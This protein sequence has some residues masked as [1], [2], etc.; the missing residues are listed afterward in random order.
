MRKTLKIATAALLA[1]VVGT[2][3]ALAHEMKGSTA[4]PGMGQGMMGSQMK[5][6]S[7]MGAGMMMGGGY[8]PC[9]NQAGGKDLSADDARTILDGHL[10]MMGHKRLKVG[11][12]TPD[13][14]GALIADI[15]TLDGSLVLKMEV[16]PGTGAMH[17]V[18]E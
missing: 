18:A 13:K 16:D 4:A 5:M 15:T 14:D 3:V 2:G 9:Q 8:G 7:G 6:H 1:V 10:M 17:M 12:V 11:D